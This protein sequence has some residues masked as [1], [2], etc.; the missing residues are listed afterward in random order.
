M[1]SSFF[2][3]T[4]IIFFLSCA[5]V[6]TLIDY[7]AAYS[8]SFS[9]IFLKDVLYH[10]DVTYVFGVRLKSLIQFLGCNFVEVNVQLLLQV[11]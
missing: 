3:N 1:I 6:P 2:T 8:I 9:T 7:L 10:L 5:L 4:Y 11:I